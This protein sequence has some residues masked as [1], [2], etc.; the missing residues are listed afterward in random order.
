MSTAPRT[1]ESTAVVILI[2]AL[3]Y[4]AGWSYAYHCYDRFDLGL[5]GLGIP[6]EYNFM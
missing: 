4:A 1:L 3:I 6:I 5:I 2:A